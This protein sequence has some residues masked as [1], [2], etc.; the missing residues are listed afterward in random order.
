MLGIH[1]YIKL[2]R[3]GRRQL[4][5]E[6]TSVALWTRAISELKED[7]VALFSLLQSDPSI[8]EFFETKDVIAS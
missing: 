2:N 3:V 5:L 1:R 6:P 4:L 8:L 7:E